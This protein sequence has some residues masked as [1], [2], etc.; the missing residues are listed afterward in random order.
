MDDARIKTLQDHPFPSNISQMR[1]FLGSANFFLRH[2][3]LADVAAPLHDATSS[4]FDWKDPVAVAALRPHFDAVIAKCVDAV[5]L[6]VPDYNLPWILRTDASTVAC[7][8]VLCQQYP[9]THPQFP[10]ILAPI[11]VCSHKFSDPATRW[12]TYEQE[13]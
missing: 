12:S 11:A 13:A 7:G 5:A 6:H 3:Q 4:S 2:V 8:A 10:G 1:S 9:P